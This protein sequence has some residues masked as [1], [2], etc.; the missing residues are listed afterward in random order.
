M[1]VVDRGF[2]VAGSTLGRSVGR[3]L[4]LSIGHRTLLSG[5]NF[6]W[7]AAHVSSIDK[8]EITVECSP[9]MPG[10]ICYF[11]MWTLAY[12]RADRVD[13]PQYRKCW[14]CS[15]SYLGTTWAMLFEV[16]NRR[17]GIL[18][19]EPLSHNLPSVYHVRMTELEFKCYRQ[20]D[21]H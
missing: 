9:P 18:M 16:C 12:G 19:F 11:V 21:Q 1:W 4:D 2:W 3:S 14:E 17:A 7:A 5:H 20:T 10:P 6:P 13:V 15:Q 8:S